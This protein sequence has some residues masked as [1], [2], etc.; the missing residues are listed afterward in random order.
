[1]CTEEAIQHSDSV[2]VGEAENLWATVVNDAQNGRIQPI[3]KAAGKIDLKCSPIPTRSGLQR[4]R[5]LS[6]VL[7]TAKGCPEQCETFKANISA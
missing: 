5:Y 7:Q 2:V 3:Y 6:D 1:M 4:D